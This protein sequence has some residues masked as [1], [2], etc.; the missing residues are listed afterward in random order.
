M[1]E[2]VL[3]IIIVIITIRKRNK[4]LSYVITKIWDNDKGNIMIG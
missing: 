2:V 1:Y 3:I 4:A